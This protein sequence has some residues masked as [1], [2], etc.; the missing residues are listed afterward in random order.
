MT[1]IKELKEIDRPMFT[2]GKVHFYNICDVIDYVMPNYWEAHTKEANN[3]MQKLVK[4]FQNSH[5]M[6]FYSAPREDFSFLEAEKET[7]ELN[8]TNCIVEDLS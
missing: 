5:S 2:N 7:L 8:L 6:H 4:K 1:N 3:E